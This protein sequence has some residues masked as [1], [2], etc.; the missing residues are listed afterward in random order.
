[1][2]LPLRKCAAQRS[3]SGDHASM[4]TLHNDSQVTEGWHCQ[5]VML[6]ADDAQQLSPLTPELCQRGCICTRTGS[7]QFFRHR[8]KP[9]R[10]LGNQVIQRAPAVAAVRMLERQPQ[11][12]NAGATLQVD[13]LRVHAQVARKCDRV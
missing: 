13:D 6:P 3:A 10:H 9:Q 12:R 4:F 7:L 11:L 2:R 5:R 8:N 1:M